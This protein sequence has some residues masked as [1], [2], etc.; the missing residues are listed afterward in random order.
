[1]GCLQAPDPGRSAWLDQLDSARAHAVRV[2]TELASSCRARLLEPVAR[3]GPWVRGLVDSVASRPGVTRTLCPHLAG[4]RGPCPSLVTLPRLLTCYGCLPA[5]VE[6]RGALPDGCDRCGQPRGCRIVV[7]R[8]DTVVAVGLLC[9]DCL[10]VEL[11]A[12]R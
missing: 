9:A 2:A 10:A 5:A 7:A 12:T 4:G 8:H 3:P 1:M 11:A 6:S